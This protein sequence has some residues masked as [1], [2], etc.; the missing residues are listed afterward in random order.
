MSTRADTLDLAPLRLGSGAGH[1]AELEVEL[2][3]FD[4]S[5]QVYDVDPAVVPVRLDVSRTTANGYALRLRFAATL[6]G[7]CMRC[8]EPSRS[9]FEVDAREVDQPGAEDEELD[10]PYVDDEEVVDVARWVNDALSLT[11]PAQLLCRDDCAG[12]CAECGENLNASPDHAHEAGPDPRWAKL[13]ELQ[14]P[15]E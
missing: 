1:T 8:L 3:P 7:P 9:T 6:A 2:E 15:Q 4:L 14:L 11:L 5:G 10:S 13:R 12:L